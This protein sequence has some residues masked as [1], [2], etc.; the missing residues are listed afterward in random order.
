ME[1]KY[2]GTDD[3]KNQT[4]YIEFSI[5]KDERKRFNLIS[6]AYQAAVLDLYV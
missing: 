4:N 1:E 2:S 6:D 3:E 5:I